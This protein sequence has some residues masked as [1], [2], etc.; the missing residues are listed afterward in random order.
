MDSIAGYGFFDARDNAIAEEY[1]GKH[2][3]CYRCRVPDYEMV[4]DIFRG[5]QRLSLRCS[6]NRFA[7]F[8]GSSRCPSFEPDPQLL[9]LR[10]DA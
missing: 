2:W 4:R 3:A 6:V 8:A 1:A 7:P 10:L 5:P 9:E